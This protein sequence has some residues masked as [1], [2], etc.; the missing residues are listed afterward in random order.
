MPTTK[1]QQ[2]KRKYD[3]FDCNAINTIFVGDK[4]MAQYLNHK[5]NDAKI[6]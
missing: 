6:S 5:I 2:N 4:S 3:G 1:K